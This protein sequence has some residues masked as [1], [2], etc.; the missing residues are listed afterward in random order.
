MKDHW[1]WSFNFNLISFLSIKMISQQTCERLNWSENQRVLLFYNHIIVDI[2]SSDTV[3]RQFTDCKACDCDLGSVS[4]ISRIQNVIDLILL[5]S[6]MIIHYSW[7]Y[8]RPF[9]MPWDQD[10]AREKNRW[11]GV[12]WCHF[13]FSNCFQPFPPS[14]LLLCLPAFLLRGLI[15]VLAAVFSLP[16]LKWQ[17]ETSK[18]FPW[19]KILAR[20]VENRKETNL[21]RI[22]V[23]NG[24][25]STSPR[26][27]T[28]HARLRIITLLHLH[29]KF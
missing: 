23:V 27:P 22:V 8:N 14:F 7:V 18:M 2:F 3:A 13:D 24:L 10:E 20:I 12:A 17:E 4:W 16:N 15:S 19:G 5:S 29:N 6:P 26:E 28:S 9:S 1:Y 25:H 11:K 21:A